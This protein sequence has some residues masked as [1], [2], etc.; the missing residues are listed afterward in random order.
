MPALQN[1]LDAIHAMPLEQRVRVMHLSGDQERVINQ[2]GLRRVL[3]PNVELIAGPGCSASICPGSDVYQAV[4]LAQDHDVTLAVDESLLS[5]PTPAGLSGAQSLADA[6]RLGADVRVITAPIEAVLLATAA[7]QKQVVLFVAGFETLLAPLAGMLLDGL[8]DNL[9]LLLCGRRVEPLVTERQQGA[10]ADFDALLLPGNRCSLVG[11][12]DWASFATS[13]GKP[14][15]VAGYTAT[16]LL[17]AIQA[18]IESLA[19]G[20]AILSNCYQPFAKP[21]G[22]P[23]AQRRLAEVFELATGNWRGIGAVPLS[24][25]SL[26]DRFAA[27]DAD[28]KFPDYRHFADGLSDFAE[29]CGCAGVIS[30]NALPGACDEFGRTCR[31]EGPIG[32]CMASRDGTCYA[33]FFANSPIAWSQVAR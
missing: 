23:T 19:M 5:V 29:G 13:R 26:R 14:V 27:A 3:P 21:G 6:Q 2:S 24:G 32:P 18:L 10:L 7:P 22:N 31:P 30:G 1:R 25:Y 20:H 28:Q 17:V 8:P 16:A 12:S 4:R 9:S 11:L 33:Q 15:A